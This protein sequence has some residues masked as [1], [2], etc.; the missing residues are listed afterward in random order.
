MARDLTITGFEDRPGV[1]AAIGEAL[2]EAGVNIEG[3]FGSGKFLEI[4]VL[5]EDEATAR[6]ALEEAGFTVSDARDVLVLEVENR[7]GAWGEVA[8]R[9]A[10]AGV[11]IDFH[12]IAMNNRFVVAA[13][14]LEKARAAV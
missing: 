3:T 11:N 6:Q 5:V 2:G 10:D 9:I 12:Y 13:D 1:T 14:D 8:R 4:H 7:P